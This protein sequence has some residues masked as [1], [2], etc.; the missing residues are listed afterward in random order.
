VKGKYIVKR[1]LHDVTSRKEVSLRKENYVFILKK[2]R[3]DV[4]KMDFK[5]WLLDLFSPTPY[6]EPSLAYRTPEVSEGWK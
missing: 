4:K 3:I 6:N 1:A 5:S 2:Y